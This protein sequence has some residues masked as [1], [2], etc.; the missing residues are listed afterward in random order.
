MVGNEACKE[1]YFYYLNNQYRTDWKRG[2]S[3]YG[4]TAIINTAVYFGIYR[5]NKS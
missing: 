4:E 1:K 2:I 3:N 5:A